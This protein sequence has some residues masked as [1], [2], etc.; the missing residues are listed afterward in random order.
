MVMGIVFDEESPGNSSGTPARHDSLRRL[1]D[2]GLA[3]WVWADAHTNIVTP[4]S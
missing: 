3:R 1:G 4:R 2:V